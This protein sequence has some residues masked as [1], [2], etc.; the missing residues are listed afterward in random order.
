MNL[1][2][3]RIEAGHPGPDEPD[4]CPVAKRP[5]FHF[6]LVGPVQAGQATGQHTGIADGGLVRNERDAD[7]AQGL[8]HGQ[9]ADHLNVG[10]AAADKREVLYKR[11]GLIHDCFYFVS[12]PTPTQT[13]PSHFGRRRTQKYG[14]RLR[15][16][17]FKRPRSHGIGRLRD[18]G[19][20][21]TAREWN[22]HGDTEQPKSIMTRETVWTKDH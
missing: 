22:I 16:L 19:N 14:L 21:T 15:R 5:Q 6:H 9:H 7:A 11:D 17:R 8:L 2:E 3:D 12:T 18:P 4:T 20:P 10:V 1:L 13:Q